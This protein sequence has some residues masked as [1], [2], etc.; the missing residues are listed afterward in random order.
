MN[1]QN[2]STKSR[3]KGAQRETKKS[4]H[5]DGIVAQHFSQM[6]VK[7]KM[8]CPK[9]WKLTGKQLTNVKNREDISY[10]CSNS[11][12]Y[13]KQPTRGTLCSM[14]LKRRESHFNRESP[15]IYTERIS[16]VLV[17]SGGIMCGYSTFNTP[18][19]LRV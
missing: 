19:K 17:F 9:W 13:M 15:R 18:T 14:V 12:N 5:G 7:K 16:M 8:F 2:D 1:K 4:R 10:N 3:G 11:E 6:S